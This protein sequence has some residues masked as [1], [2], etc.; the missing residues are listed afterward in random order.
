[1]FDGQSKLLSDGRILSACT[2]NTTPTLT[3][4]R[5]LQNGTLDASF[6]E[7]GV[8]RIDMP[9]SQMA[10][11]AR[12]EVQPDDSALVYG[13]IG[14]SGSHHSFVCKVLPDGTI[15]SAFGVAGFCILDFGH[16][17]ELVSEIVRLDDGKVMALVSGPGADGL[18]DVY[19]VRLVNG[20]LDPSFGD[21]GE[22]YV[23]VSRLVTLHFAV[24]ASGGYVMT[25]RTDFSTATFR[26]Y[27]PDGSLDRSFGEN[28]QVTVPLPS[29]T[30]DARFNQVSVQPDGKIL[31]VGYANVGT[32]NHT[33]TIRLNPDGSTDSTFNGGEPKIM[34][35]QGH[36]SRNENA[37][38]LPD[39]RIVA[40][41]DILDRPGDI[42]LMRL[43]PNGNLDASF[44]S[45]G[46]VI[47]N[48]GGDDRCQG[49][50]VQSDGKILVCGLRVMESSPDRMYLAR[51]LG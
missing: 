1:M 3:M 33:L 12:M 17:S 4:V 20:H 32:G 44:G 49:L 48:P 24:T 40:A 16:Q 19:L 13:P 28:G 29:P 51:Y 9:D 15:D 30:G 2:D 23:R 31:A 7:Q 22:G 21:N 46:L 26:Q 18:E 34:V 36:Q 41:G 50:Q 42:C 35:F 37:V 38:Y 10:A 43:Q 14:R 45:N 6:G 11:Y 39:G 8:T 5:H 25:P 27:L 47:S